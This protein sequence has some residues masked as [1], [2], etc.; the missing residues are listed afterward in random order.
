MPSAPASRQFL[1]NLGTVVTG[2]AAAQ[3]VALAAVPL[4]TR[5]YDPAAFGAF[6]LL[7]ALSGIA[8][9]VA[10][11]RWELAVVLPARD[12]DAA[13]VVALAAL[14]ALGTASMAAVV[15]AV[16]GDRLPRAELLW[17][18]PPSLLL[19]ALAEILAQWALRRERYRRVAA[20]QGARSAATVAAQ[21]AA[22]A[23]APLPAG[24]LGGHLL[25]QA[26]Q[27]AVLLRGAPRAWPGLRRLA[28][29]AARYREFPLFGAPQAL[30]NALSQYGPAVMLAA[31][32]EATVGL[33]WLA[34]RVLTL[35]DAV[36]NQP[37]RQVFYRDAS[38]AGADLRA[39][40]LRATA[41]LAALGL[42][43]LLAAVLA[44]PELFAWAFGEGWREAGA[45]ARWLAPWW[46][47]GFVNVP[48]VA[49]IPLLHLQ[50]AFLG[51]EVVLAAARLGALAAGA[52]V[53]GPLTAVAAY[54]LVGAA[55]NAALVGFVL[56]AAAPARRCAP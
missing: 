4:L 15:L 3:A 46:F 23:L 6:G 10:A 14:A 41:A 33:Y 11:G 45:F 47:L 39:R 17:W 22:G 12:E 30:V 9:T 53:A 26:A 38:R 19:A 2:A 48:S 31:F 29:V 50:K 20:G 16:A 36:L 13:G 18:L 54:A 1:R 7:A 52:A 42:P 44:G 35:P 37:L 49:A 56:H 21:A 8:A 40:L 25:G 27:V 43:V 34:L 28:A 24:L 55:F 32:G 51:Y 5:L